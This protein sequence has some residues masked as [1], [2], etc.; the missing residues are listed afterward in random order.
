MCIFV[1]LIF[2]MWHLWCD[3]IYYL[4]KAYILHTVSYV[5]MIFLNRQNSSWQHDMSRATILPVKGVMV[6]PLIHL[7]L[8]YSDYY[9][10]IVYNFKF[11]IRGIS[12]NL[13]Y[14]VH[15][16]FQNYSFP[17]WKSVSPPHACYL[18][19]VVFYS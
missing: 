3:L 11:I 12:S 15:H 10:F 8:P 14:D 1:V 7:L 2:K 18:N 17:L 13:R 19:K 16:E 5:D 9:F 6:L 4:D